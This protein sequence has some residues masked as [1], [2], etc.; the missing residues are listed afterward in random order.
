MIIN[1]DLPP[2]IETYSHRIGRTGRYGK[3]GVSVVFISPADEQFITEN[4]ASFS[5]LK[6]V[7]EYYDT[8]NLELEKK[9]QEIEINK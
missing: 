6:D 9:H 5:G 8:I 7:S 1:F 2:T 4:D 3:Y